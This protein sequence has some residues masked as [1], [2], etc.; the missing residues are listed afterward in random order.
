[1]VGSAFCSSIVYFWTPSQKDFKIVA[2]L[3]VLESVKM[4]VPRL[5]IF[6]T[7]I[8]V[9]KFGCGVVVCLEGVMVGGG[10][11]HGECIK[12]GQFLDHYRKGP[13]FLLQWLK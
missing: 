9:C 10:Q 13:R 1:M 11:G 12:E 7:Y 5:I 6:E 3:L 8:L 4:H 2:S